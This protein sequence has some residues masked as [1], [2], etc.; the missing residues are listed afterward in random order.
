MKL[1]IDDIIED[2]DK[3]LLTSNCIT[4]FRIRL[5]LT[6]DNVVIVINS[7]TSF[8]NLTFKEIKKSTNLYTFKEILELFKNYQ[9]ELIL[10]ISNMND[11]TN[12]FI[13]LIL[14]EIQRYNNLNFSFETS[15][16][17]V[18]QYLKGI[19]YPSYLIN[20]D[21]SIIKRKDKNYSFAKVSSLTNLYRLLNNH[22][23]S[24]PLYIIIQKE[25]KKS[26]LFNTSLLRLL[27]E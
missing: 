25:L 8:N 26:S 23:K 24:F 15:D 14:V 10:T 7:D 11:K 12:L 18:Y 16:D 22:P 20:E 3:L 6:S 13:D 5:G 19:N 17:T 27:E 2:N 9:K 1:I 21:K 4:G